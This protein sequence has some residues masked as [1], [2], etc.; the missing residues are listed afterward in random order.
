MAIISKTY[1]KILAILMTCL[2]FSAIIVSCVEYGAPMAT[3]KAKGVAFSEKDNTPVEG[4]RAVL[5]PDMYD[6][7][8][9]DATYTNSQGV[10]N[11]KSHSGWNTLYVVLSDERNSAFK[12]TTIVADFSHV[13]FKGKIRNDSE[14]EKDLGVIK[15]KPKQ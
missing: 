2:G 5:K 10:F 14:V 15:M 3:Y 13:K 8:E 1:G 7:W 12:D 6:A 11:L 4:I 9:M